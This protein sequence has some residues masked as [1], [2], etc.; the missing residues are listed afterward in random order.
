VL[1]VA[2]QLRRLCSAT[3]ANLEALLSLN[4]NIAKMILG[5]FAVVDIEAGYKLL[6]DI[7][8]RVPPWHLAMDHPAIF[9]FSPPHSRC[10]LNGL[11]RSDRLTDLLHKGFDIFW[12]NRGSPSPSQQFL[13]RLADKV[14]PRLIEEIK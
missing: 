1:E 6:D 13:Q 10:F 3:V 4:A 11:S 14:E 5:T 2:I 12:M 9:R 8:V 7:S